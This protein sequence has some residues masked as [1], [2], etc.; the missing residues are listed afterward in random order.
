[1][2]PS[3][4]WLTPCSDTGG[5]VLWP[6][7]ARCAFQPPMFASASRQKPVPFSP[8]QVLHMELCLVLTQTHPTTF[9]L[10]TWF[11]LPSQKSFLFCQT[12]P[13]LSHSSMSPEVHSCAACSSN[14]CGPGGVSW[15]RGPHLPHFG[16]RKKQLWDILMD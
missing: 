10:T 14:P 12:S 6:S 1:M 13:Q 7:P 8:G 5:Q 9:P 11:K 3:L 15:P 4:T 2:Q 16:K